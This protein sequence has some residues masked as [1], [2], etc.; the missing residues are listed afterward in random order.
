MGKALEKLKMY[1]SAWRWIEA[2]CTDKWHC[3]G[4]QIHPGHC[5]FV[6]SQGCGEAQ[7][8]GHQV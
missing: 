8:T 5:V 2:E 4:K 1:Y 7:M 6:P 3:G